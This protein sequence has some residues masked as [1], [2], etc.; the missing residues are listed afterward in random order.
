MDPWSRCGCKAA[1][2]MS[3]WQIA[4]AALAWGEFSSVLGAVSNVRSR[5]TGLAIGQTR[6][7][8]P[9]AARPRAGEL[10]RVGVDA[11]WDLEPDGVAL[12]YRVGEVRNAVRAHAGGGPQVVHVIGRTDRLFLRAREGDIAGTVL[13]RPDP[14]IPDSELPQLGLVERSAARGVGPVRHS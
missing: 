5:R 4:T 2:G 13:E 3:F 10:R 6:R 14:R 7:Y 12:E 9:D 1:G 11:R 8:Q